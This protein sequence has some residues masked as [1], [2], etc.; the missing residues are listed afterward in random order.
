MSEQGEAFSKYTT[1]SQ[2]YPVEPCHDVLSVWEVACIT[3][4]LENLSN[5]GRENEELVSKSEQSAGDPAVDDEG[6]YSAQQA[7]FTPFRPCQ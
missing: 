3:A 5:A 2:D 7:L 6:I 1:K 4:A